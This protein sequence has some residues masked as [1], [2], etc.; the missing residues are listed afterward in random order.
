VAYWDFL[1]VRSVKMA[2][3]A[4]QTL[5]KAI[6]LA[7]SIEKDDVCIYSFT[8]TYG[9]MITPAEFISHLEKCVALIEK[10]AGP[11]LY[12]RPDHEIIPVKGKQSF[13]MMTL[14]L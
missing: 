5:E 14:N 7:R 8:R 11:R 9:E 3:V 12:E 13:L 4:L 2:K 10:V 6:G 1:P